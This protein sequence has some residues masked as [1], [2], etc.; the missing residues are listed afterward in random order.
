MASIREFKKDINLI[1]EIV[2][3]DCL[4]YIDINPGKDKKKIA[5]IIN[6]MIDKRNEL[7][8]KINKR[9]KRASRSENKS[10]LNE[11]FGE[12][13]NAADNCFEELSAQ[14]KK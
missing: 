3:T 8:T 6:K 1:T 11:I 2:I 12:L 14:I 10:Y 7:I 13:L 5:E 9:N 4:L